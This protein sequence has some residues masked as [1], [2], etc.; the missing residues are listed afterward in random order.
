M[1]E[2]GRYAGDERPAELLRAGAADIVVL[3][4]DRELPGQRRAAQHGGQQRRR[5][6]VEGAAGAGGRGSIGQ[7]LATL[8]DDP[9][10]A[11]VGFVAPAKV[12]QVGQRQFGQQHSPVGQRYAQADGDDA[13]QRRQVF[14]APDDAP[15]VPNLEEHRC[16]RQVA[17][18]HFGLQVTVARRQ[19]GGGHPAVRRKQ[20]EGAEGLALANRLVH[21]LAGPA[22]VVQR[23]AEQEQLVLQCAE[24]QFDAQ[25]Q[26]ARVAFGAAADFL[27]QLRNPVEQEDRGDDGEAEHRGQC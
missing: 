23:F 19:T 4:V 17:A 9:D 16:R 11:L 12:E 20:V 1:G 10:G 6:E 2:A 26:F 21:Q 5:I 25:G 14:V 8:V 7:D 15:P 22:M 18:D 3:A 13:G 24:L 27:F